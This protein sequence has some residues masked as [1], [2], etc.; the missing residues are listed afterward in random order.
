MSERDPMLALRGLIDEPIAPR[1]AFAE[2]LR[3]RL[4]TEL[5]SHRPPAISEER[6]MEITTP[7]LQLV[8]PSAKP[9]QL[10]SW[11]RI[12]E[13]AAIALLLFGLIA[14]FASER[15]GSPSNP[16]PTMEAVTG[17]APA[18]S[19]SPE[20]PLTAASPEA[21]SSVLWQSAWTGPGGDI[22]SAYA[23]ANGMIYRFQADDA[24][25][26]IEAIDA[27]TG[28]VA[29]RSAV[30]GDG[31][32]ADSNG[33]YVTLSVFPDPDTRKEQ[34]TIV[35]LDPATGDELWSFA[36]WAG[37]TEPI[38][39]DSVLY[40]RQSTADIV[41]SSTFTEEIRA[42]DTSTGEEVWVETIAAPSVDITSN[43]PLPQHSMAIGDDIVALVS[44][45]GSI[46]GLDRST[47]GRLWEQPGF[48]ANATDLGI[49]G[50]TLIASSYFYNNG[51]PEGFPEITTQSAVVAMKLSDGTP[52]WSQDLGDLP[53][54]VA[55]AQGYAIV[56]I[57]ADLLPKPDYEI[58][59]PDGA[60]SESDWATVG[61]NV[62]TGERDVNGGGGGGDG[63]GP[64]P[65]AIDDGQF[66]LLIDNNVSASFRVMEPT[67]GNSQP[68][69]LLLGQQIVGSP[70]SDGEHLYLQL[71]D[72]TIVAV[73][74]AMPS[75]PATAAEI[76]ELMPETGGPLPESVVW[77]VDQPVPWQPEWM[78]LPLGGMAVA[79]GY[80]YRALLTFDLSQGDQS[81]PGIEA[82]DARTGE[83]LWQVPA[84][85]MDGGFTFGDAITAG[86]GAVYIVLNTSAE[87][88]GPPTSWDLIA[89]NGADGS[90]RWRVSFEDTS[91]FTDP[92]ADPADDQSIDT[93]TYSD[94]V[95]YISN[96]SSVVTAI[97]AESGEQLWK[98][99]APPGRMLGGPATVVQEGS[100][101]DLSQNSAEGSQVSITRLD[102]RVYV[103]TAGGNVAV[104]DAATG[105]TVGVA[106]P[107]S[108]EGASK[109]VVIG[110]L[111]IV[112]NTVWDHTDAG[113]Q[114]GKSGT[115]TAFD[116][117]NNYAMVWE[118][119]M[120]G[121]V[122]YPLVIDGKLF[123]NV[124]TAGSSDQG[125]IDE[126]DPQ[127]GDVFRAGSIDGQSASTTVAIDGTQYIVA[128]SFF[129][130]SFSL[131]DPSTGEIVASSQDV[132]ALTFIPGN[133]G[134]LY[135]TLL[136]G[137]LVAINPLTIQAG[138]A[139]VE[140]TPT[141]VAVTPESTAT[142]D[143]SIA[144]PEGL[145]W[146]STPESGDFE[147]SSVAF[148]GNVV[149]RAI[150]TSDFYGV[151]GLN[152]LS[153]EQLWSREME[154][155]G[156]PVSD[157]RVV[158]VPA[159]SAESGTGAIIAIDPL[160]GDTRWETTF[161]GQVSTPNLQ[162]DGLY[163]L[164]SN[165]MVTML[166]PATGEKVWESVMDSSPYSL[167]QF[168]DLRAPAVANNAV[169]A[170]SN[171][172]SMFAF[173]RYAGGEIW[174]KPGYSVATARYAAAGDV[175]VVVD[176]VD[177][178]ATPEA[179]ANQ[180]LPMRIERIDL[181]TGEV[182][183]A[184]PALFNLP[185]QPIVS[186]S[187]NGVGSV[188][189]ILAEQVQ[190]AGGVYDENGFHSDATPSAEPFNSSA[191][192]T[193][194][195]IQASS[196]DIASL[197][198]DQQFPYGTLGVN[199]NGGLITWPART[200]T[201]NGRDIDLGQPIYGPP[202]TD[203]QIFLVT[204]QDGTLV[205]LDAGTVRPG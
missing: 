53:T 174:S 70:L 26:G 106:T 158:Y 167:A 72:G 178:T 133:N 27:V 175:L 144:T 121:S 64:D 113:F 15:A 171:S 73:N 30:M 186:F 135:A 180:V 129:D 38:V 140:T 35:A 198:F 82:Y 66:V 141:E 173:D 118:Q 134:L 116:I 83:R 188:I 115:L 21:E 78:G 182:L 187:T 22:P 90:E 110:N 130:G 8:V 51:A 181:L 13:V 148:A 97:D 54:N 100:I 12:A 103:V 168:P 153:G 183:W 127:T 156:A 161:G 63:R 177:T 184:L 136:D 52:L 69:N 194:F 199:D 42:I 172:G 138:E 112:A 9:R 149:I 195:T 33:V 193:L 169:V 29:W 179:S 65:I 16:K 108:T 20:K 28:A 75:P 58:A 176:T 40:V 94:G 137:T 23:L 119:E 196:G 85:F 19:A 32:A 2:E 11:R 151:Q 68:S 39:K 162:L 92:T 1:A 47:G 142:P 25:Q 56:T 31:V 87:E 44:S 4:L 124:V 105:A 191:E 62:E 101:T 93:L 49:W 122:Q 128:N 95:I 60:V 107:T 89:L 109:P 91:L 131:I 157:G 123:V 204:L 10:P 190:T 80:V 99:E 126:I 185:D 6:T 197:Q 86:D 84:K 98:S 14:V 205:A 36:T 76:A 45:R 159:N 170:I 143:D 166:D 152:S 5:G 48:P 160:S 37:E 57:D 24:F 163:V 88:D 34:K 3:A 165:D 96:W 71:Q 61:F 146:T 114:I 81:T 150:K 139:A 18:E 203:N 7:G 102:D 201:N 147:G 55:V 154:W 104:L 50:D 164:S 145:L 79:D 43:L 74:Q 120:G 46:F 59:T 41:D 202:A 117:S 132:P 189:Y 200:P 67:S 17:L 77:H 155:T 192:G 111:L 125:A